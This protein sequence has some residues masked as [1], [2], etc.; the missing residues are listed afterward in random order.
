MK[1]NNNNYWLISHTDNNVIK[2]DKNTFNK[3]RNDTFFF[4]LV[5]IIYL[6]L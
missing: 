1:K 5:L 3:I 2:I 4:I 6:V